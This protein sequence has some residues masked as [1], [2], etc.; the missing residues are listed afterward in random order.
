MLTSHLYL[1]HLRLFPRHTCSG[2]S[3]LDLSFLFQC[4]ATWSVHYGV[5]T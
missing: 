1:F 5:S 4:T 2:I 3:F